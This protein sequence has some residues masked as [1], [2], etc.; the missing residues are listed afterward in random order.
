MKFPVTRSAQ[1]KLPA[2]LNVLQITPKNIQHAVAVYYEPRAGFDASPPPSP[3]RYTYRVGSGDQLRIRVWTTPERSVSEGDQVSQ[4]VEGPVVDETGMFFYPFVGEIRARGRTVRQIRAELT[5]K[6]AD[7]LRTPQVE[8]AVAEYRAHRVM[9]TGAVGSPGPTILTNVPLTLVDLLNASGISPKS[10]LSHVALR[11][12]GV[13]Y[14]VNAQLFL[15]EGQTRHNPTLLPGDTVHVPELTDN[16]V[17]VFGEIRTT[18]LPLTRGEQSLTEILASLGGIDRQRANARGVFV[19]RRTKVTGDGFD[20]V[21]QFDLS[22][23]STLITMKSFPMMPQD[24]VFVTKDPV[25]RWTDT[26]G[27]VLAPASSL[28]SGAALA[29][30]FTGDD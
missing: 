27:R 6:L 28:A 22:D 1:Q 8:L 29:E 14:T 16:V 12:R 10:D 21:F 7:Y 30:Q 19:F 23:A 25:T 18:A 17:Y 26:V 5:R 24:I 20:V 15:E 13:E 9:I 3:A 4:Q 11:R 2:N